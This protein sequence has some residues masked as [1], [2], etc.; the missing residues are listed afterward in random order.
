MLGEAPATTD[1]VATIE[2]RAEAPGLPDRT[3]DFEGAYGRHWDDGEVHAFEHFWGFA[4][5]VTSDHA[6]MGGPAEG[7]NRWVTVRNSMLFVTARLFLARG[8]FVLHGAAIRRGDDGLLVVGH[9]GSGK[10]TLAYAARRAG[11]QV[12][13]DDM[14]VVEPTAAGLR[15]RGIPRVPSI[16]GDVAAL[17]DAQ[18]EALPPVDTRNR[19][20]LVGDEMDHT[21]AAARAV[22]VCGH[23]DGAASA[24]R[25]DAVTALHELVPA[26]VLAELREPMR[27]WFPHASRLANVSC[28][29]FAHDV[30]VDERLPRAAIVLDEILDASVDVDG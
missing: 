8:V 29:R 26:F 20:E 1:P 5:R 14:V 16:P 9:S 25:T 22:V 6:V 18:G 17:T 28:W 2:L 23:S 4:A 7:H 21:P 30:D 10:S 13:G 24:T 15:L 12:L 27:R 3:P 11:W 19:I